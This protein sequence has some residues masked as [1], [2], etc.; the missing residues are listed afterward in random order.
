MDE[1]RVTYATYTGNGQSAYLMG[2]P[3]QDMTRA[4]WDAAPKELTALAVTLKLYSLA[5]GKPAAPVAPVSP[6]VEREP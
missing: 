3:M 1:Q 2:L 6:K 5:G 4:E